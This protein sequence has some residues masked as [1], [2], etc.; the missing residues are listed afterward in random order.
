MNGGASKE[1]VFLAI[2]AAAT[3]MTIFRELYERNI[4]I[5]VKFR[6]IQRKQDALE[7]KV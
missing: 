6:Q 1:R 7:E 3:N 5:T 4:K 2:N